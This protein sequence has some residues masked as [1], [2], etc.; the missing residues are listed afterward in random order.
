MVGFAEAEAVLER[1]VIDR[2]ELVEALAAS[3]VAGVPAAGAR[4]GIDGGRRGPWRGAVVSYWHEAATVEVLA[5]GLP[6]D[7][8]AGGRYVGEGGGLG[9]GTII[10]GEL[11]T[12]E[13]PQPMPPAH[14][15]AALSGTAVSANVERTRA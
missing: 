10:S 13:E 5:G 8:R 1:R 4:G 3:D 6:T 12:A 2:E 14:R 11:A 15:G 9:G 7:R